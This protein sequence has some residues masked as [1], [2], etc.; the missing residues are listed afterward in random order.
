MQIFIEIY[1]SKLE[2]VE[3]YTV[4]L[5]RKTLL[6]IFKYFQNNTGLI[7][8]FNKYLLSTYHMPS[9][10]LGPGDNQPYRQ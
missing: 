10:I 9:K 7:K 1:L 2:K 4:F 6:E 3:K 5:S 8:T